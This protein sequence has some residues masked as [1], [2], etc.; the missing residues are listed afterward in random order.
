MQH[1]APIG[2][3][4]IVHLDTLAKCKA[5]QREAIRLAPPGHTRS[6]A[7][8]MYRQIPIWADLSMP[9]E[10]WCPCGRATL[11]AEHVDFQGACGCSNGRWDD[12][13]C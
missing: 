10:K 1:P 7:H 11:D 13:Q 5:I 9:A 8:K 4:A 12:Y 3:A 2:D 6:N